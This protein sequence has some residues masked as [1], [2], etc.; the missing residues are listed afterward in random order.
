M[1]NNFRPARFPQQPAPVR[2]LPGGQPPNAMRPNGPMRP[3]APIGSATFAALADPNRLC[4]LDRICELGSC[5]TKRL[6]E[7]MPIT[8]QAATRHLELLE[9]VGILS[10]KRRGRERIWTLHPEMLGRAS[11]Y[12]GQ[13]ARRSAAAEQLRAANN[14][15]APNYPGAG[16]DVPANCRPHYYA[17]P[18]QERRNPNGA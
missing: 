14:R 9:S 10:S 18:R 15:Q 3:L 7:T 11:G 13:L 2:R 6:T 4:L 17:P 5:S 12:L 16:R 1:D 8:R